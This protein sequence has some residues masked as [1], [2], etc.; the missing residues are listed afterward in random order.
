MALCGEMEIDHR[1]VQAAMAQILLDTSDINAGFQE[2]SGVTVAQ[3]VNGNTFCDIELF[4]YASQG[5]LHGGIAHRLLGCWTLIASMS[6]SWKDPFGVSMGYPVLAQDM[7]G[8]LRQGD[9]SVF[10]A[11]S[12]VD[13]NAQSLGVDVGYLKEQ[14][15]MQPEATRINGGEIG[16]VLDGIDRIDEGP[17][18]FDA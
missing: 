3:G 4:K 14:R 2:M 6:E 1:G 16:F 10:G 17:D 11:F 7:K 8:G 15:F 9:I 18:L 5:P 12:P 13:M